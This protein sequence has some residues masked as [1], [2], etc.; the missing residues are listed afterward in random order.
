MD[1]KEKAKDYAEGK[2]AA[3]LEQ[4]IADAYTDGYKAGYQD[5]DNEIPLKK[6]DDDAEWIDLGLPSG[7]LWSIPKED[8]KVIKMTYI[9]ALKKYN[10]P[11][12][13]QVKELIAYCSPAC[14]WK[15]RGPNGNEIE[16]P[17]QWGHSQAPSEEFWVKSDSDLSCPDRMN[18]YVCQG[19]FEFLNVKLSVESAIIIVR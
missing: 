6:E 3:A 2:A 19:E 10:L 17:L 9:N 14:N 11:T 12:E 15:F 8:G 1:I 18:F 5:R 13:E 4:V 16:F 7:T